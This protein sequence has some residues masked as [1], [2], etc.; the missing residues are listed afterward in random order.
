MKGHIT[1]NGI[2]LNNKE[3]Q[4]HATTWKNFAK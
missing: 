4:T 1:Y 2:I 3:K